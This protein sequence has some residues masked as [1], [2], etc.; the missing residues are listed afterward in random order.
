MP[1]RSSRPASSW[2]TRYRERGWGAG[3]TVLVAMANV[4]PGARPERSRGG[5]RPRASLRLAGH[6]AAARRGSRSIRFRPPSTPSGSREWYRRFIETRSGDAAERALATAVEAA[7]R[8]AAAESMMFAAVDGPRVPRRRPHARLH[9]QGVRGAGVRRRCSRRPVRAADGRAPDRTCLARRG[10]ERVAPS[11][12]PGGVD[13]A[14]E[15]RLDRSVGRRAEVRGAVARRTATSPTSRGRLLDDDTRA[16][17][18]TALLDAAAVGATAGTARTSGRV[19]RRRSA[20]CVS[21]RRTTTPTGTRCTTRSRPRTRCTRR[22]SATPSPE[23]AARRAPRRRCACISTGSSTCRRRGSRSP[24]PASLDELDQWW[25]E[26]GGVNEAGA[27]AYGYLRSGG[28]RAAPRRDARRRAA[29]RGRRVPLVPGVRS[30][31]PPSRWPGPKD[32]RSRRSSSPASRAS[33]PRT[34]RHVA[35]CRASS[36]SRPASAAATRSTRTSPTWRRSATRGV[37][38]VNSV[39]TICRERRARRGALPRPRR[40]SSPGRTGTRGSGRLRGAAP[41]RPRGTVISRPVIPGTA[42]AASCPRTSRARPRR[43][44]AASSRPTRV[45]LALG[46][47]DGHAERVAEDELLER[48]AGAEAQR[49]ARTARRSSAPRPR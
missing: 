24:R 16:R 36:T 32:R 10:S 6:A 28:D 9:E 8:S 47:L 14:T 27:I 44:S 19:R 48:D 13:R 43:G 39:R 31:G 1:T 11:T 33:S 12:R 3:L 41:R 37:R 4:L 25:D 34:R 40:A 35:S 21:T 38:P 18:S 30:G 5:A 29:P 42:R 17:W 46:V 23:L 2:G 26:Q 20:S 7:R 22:W 15:P 45:Q 49:R